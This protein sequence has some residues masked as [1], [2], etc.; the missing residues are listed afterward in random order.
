[1]ATS[2]MALSAQNAQQFP[3]TPIRPHHIPGKGVQSAIDCLDAL[4]L[5]LTHALPSPAPQITV[6]PDSQGIC[7]S[8]Y[9]EETWD[10]YDVGQWFGDLGTSEQ[11]FSAGVL[12]TLIEKLDEAGDTNKLYNHYSCNFQSCDT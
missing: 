4:A 12:D 10:K 9:N 6:A 11:P 8:K 7:S 3:R 2:G 5:P 1:M